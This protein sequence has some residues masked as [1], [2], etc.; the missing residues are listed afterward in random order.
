MGRSSAGGRVTDGA[1]HKLGEQERGG[2]REE[3]L[4]CEAEKSILEEGLL[5]SQPGREGGKK[6]RPCMLL[7]THCQRLGK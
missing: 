6:L 2:R 4:R 5:A 7:Q 3:D 1:R